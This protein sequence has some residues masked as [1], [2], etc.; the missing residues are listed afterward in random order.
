MRVLVVEDERITRLRIEAHLAEWGHEPV[1]CADGAEAWARFQ[2]EPCPLVITD[3]QMPAMDGLELIRRIRASTPDGSYVYAILLTARAE[4]RDVVKGM[5]TGADDFVTKPF[6]KEELRVRVRAGERIIELERALGDRNQELEAANARITGA[7]RR[8]KGD[9]EAAARVQQTFLPRQLPDLPGVGLAWSFSPCEELA[10]DMLNV[11]RLDDDHVGLWVADVC[12]HGV[13]SAL[14]SVTLSRVLA[15]LAGSDSALIRCIDG[16]GACHAVA[17][18][19]VA[20]Q[21]NQ[22]FPWNPD[23]MQFFTFLYALLNVKT[24]ELRYVSAGHPGP[25]R[26]P[27]DGDPAILPMTPP[28]V[29]IIPEAQFIEQRVS[30]DPGDRVYL[31]T[32]GITEA[33]RGGGEQFGELRLAQTLGEYRGVALTES[34]EKL[35]AAVSA[36]ADAAKPADDLS[37][38]AIEIA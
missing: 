31:Y 18:A 34:V 11:H 27:S 9:L 3:W 26:V 33:A 38:V 20:Q 13:A 32:D 21:L 6:D 37:V 30:L 16:S 28:A 25:I 29:G 1:S 14:L 35:V 5:E 4:K 23:A 22:R 8:M 15:N 12:G 2:R 24:R 7:N 17:P 36:W 10:G 19:Q